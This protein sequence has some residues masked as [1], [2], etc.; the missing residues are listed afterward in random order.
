VKV[1]RISA[2]H[3]TYASKSLVESL[4]F[5]HNNGKHVIE[6]ES[7]AGMLH[8]LNEH[9]LLLVKVTMQC[10]SRISSILRGLISCFINRM[11]FHH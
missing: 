5:E 4:M 8:S 9:L 6:Q 10:F 7:R 11:E 3:A 2:Y 1:D